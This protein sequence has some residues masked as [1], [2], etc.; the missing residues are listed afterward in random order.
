ML[1]KKSIVE[2]WYKRSSLVRK[3][4]TYLFQNP[5]WNKRVPEGFIVCPYFWL[6]MFSLLI[7]RPFFVAPIVYVVLPLMKPF[8]KPASILDEFLYKIVCTIGLGSKHNYNKGMGYALGLIAALLGACAIAL[9]AFLGIG[10]YHFYLFASLTTMGTF[11]FWSCAS[12]AGMFGVVGLHKSIT[13]TECKTLYYMFV[14]LPLFFI[15]SAIFVPHEAATSLL[16]FVQGIGGLIAYVATSVWSGICFLGYWIGFGLWIAIKYFFTWAP[17]PAFYLPWWGYLL[18]LSAIGLTADRLFCS[19]DKY[20]ERKTLAVNP[21]KVYA[22]FR[23]A[24]LTTCVNVILSEP[25]WKKGSGIE[26]ICGDKCLTAAAEAY[27]HE[28]FLQTFEQMWKTDLNSLQLKYPF[29]D[30]KAWA[31]IEKEDDGINEKFKI[32]KYHLRNIAEMPD[33]SQRKFVSTLTD[34]IENNAGVQTLAAQYRARKEEE[35]KKKEERANAWSHQMCLQVTGGISSTV[36]SIGRGFVWLFK[37]SWT[38]LAYLWMLIKAKKQG[39]CPYFRFTD[40]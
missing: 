11:M 28:L 2:S 39:A 40:D 3:N 1:V 36:K 5:L 13:K 22:R 33:F 8:G 31:E 4:F 37:Q 12:F 30:R 20:R 35:A 16:N 19:V 23:N 14:W 17:I 9:L 24:W 34:V 38:F 25:Y 18:I 6:S 10:I 7:F 26:N 27:R 21:E 29:I 32:L 15:A